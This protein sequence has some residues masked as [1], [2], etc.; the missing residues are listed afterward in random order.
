MLKGKVQKLVMGLLSEGHAG[1]WKTFVL[2]E[3]FLF[4]K[5]KTRGKVGILGIGNLPVI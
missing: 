5:I 1:H 4:I 3:Y 2:S